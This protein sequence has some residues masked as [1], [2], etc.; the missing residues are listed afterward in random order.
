[1]FAR[2]NGVHKNIYVSLNCLA[3]GT[4]VFVRI[5]KNYLYLFSC[6]PLAAQKTIS[7]VMDYKLK[8]IN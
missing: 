6:S 4:H 5:C 2:A 1:M 7:I 3:N 8:V